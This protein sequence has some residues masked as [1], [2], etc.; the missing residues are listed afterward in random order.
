MAIHSFP[1]Y[2]VSVPRRSATAKG[3]GPKKYFFGELQ[4]PAKRFCGYRGMH[5]MI[6]ITM[7]FCY[8]SIGK[9]PLDPG[10]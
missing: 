9:P 10:R 1:Q 7:R 3:F 4:K 5:G 8:R 2:F 6:L